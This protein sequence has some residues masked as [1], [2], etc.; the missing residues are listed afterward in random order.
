MSSVIKCMFKIVTKVLYFR[1]KFYSYWINLNL[2]NTKNVFFKYPIT[3]IG[4][5]FIQI[6]IGT[7]FQK[8]NVLSA[9][10][11]LVVDGKSKTPQMKIGMN[12]HFGE[13]NHITCANEITIGDNLL[14]G[15]WV[16]ITDNS[17]GNTDIET[18]FSPPTSRPITSKGKVVI[19]NNVWIGDK[20]TVLP[21]VTIGDG[22][23]IAANAVVT[24]DIPSYCIAVGN[25]AKI[26]KKTK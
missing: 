4:G 11:K 25:P 16:T 3:L 13:F 23:I 14:T 12:C 9:W 20:A 17:H 18:L 10:N 24:T 1:N 22:A 6:G 5:E 15:R 21:K 26:I 7:S 19:G 2:H 8:Y